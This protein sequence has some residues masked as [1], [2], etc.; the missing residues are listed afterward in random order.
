MAVI[1]PMVNCSGLETHYDEITTDT[2][3]NFLLVY[4]IL[5]FC[6]GKHLLHLKY[7]T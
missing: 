3:R 5:V 1:M 6:I 2:E 4:S 7:I